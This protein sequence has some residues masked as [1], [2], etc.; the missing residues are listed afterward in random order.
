LTVPI[1][2]VLAA[3]FARR[4]SRQLIL[5]GFDVVAY[6]QVEVYLGLFHPLVSPSL[7]LEILGLLYFPF[8]AKV[9]LQQAGRCYSIVQPRAGDR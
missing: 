1:H 8:P 4:L 3:G 5:S 9:H 2:L 6:H 7:Y